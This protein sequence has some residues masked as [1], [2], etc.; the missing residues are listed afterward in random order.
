[1]LFL[2]SHTKVPRYCMPQYI[3]GSGSNTKVRDLRG[4]EKNKQCLQRWYLTGGWIRKIR[5]YSEKQFAL[6]AQPD[7]YFTSN[8][9]KTNPYR[10]CTNQQPGR[11]STPELYPLCNKIL[12]V[13]TE[14]DIYV[15]KNF[16]SGEHS[17]SLFICIVTY[18]VSSTYVKIT[19]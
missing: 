12:W 9:F 3:S 17:Y 6:E 7:M 14:G 10:I 11:V 4:C 18:P 13:P 15:T 5:R 16:G 19:G 1:M 2:S 8:N